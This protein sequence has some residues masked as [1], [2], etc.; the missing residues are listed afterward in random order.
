[1]NSNPDTGSQGNKRE[2]NLRTTSV[3]L[4]SLSLL[5][6]KIKTDFPEFANTHLMP[7]H[8]PQLILFKKLIKTFSSHN[9][10][11]I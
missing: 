8:L 5:T 10:H 4:F 9:V 6:N 1:M 3:V 2:S 11:V 7:I